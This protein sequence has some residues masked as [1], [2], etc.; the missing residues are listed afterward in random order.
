MAPITTVVIESL[1]P[2]PVGADEQSESV[3]LRNKGSAPVALTGWTLR[4]RSGL[5][6]DL[7]GSLAPGQARTFR[8]NGQSMSLNNAGDEITLLD[9]AQAV[10]DLLGVH[11]VA[12]GGGDSAAVTASTQAG[13]WQFRST[14]RLLN[15]PLANLA[16]DL[17]IQLLDLIP[18][19]D[20]VNFLVG[21]E[22]LTQHRAHLHAALDVQD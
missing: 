4:D 5:H 14:L 12:G 22:L 10:R 19:F 2:N 20:Q 9:T 21:G 13:A 8:R 11:I 7:S 16:R 17:E 1:L 6:W 15:R 18:F 3:T